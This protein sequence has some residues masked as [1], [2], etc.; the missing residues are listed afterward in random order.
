MWGVKGSPFIRPQSNGK[1]DF[2]FSAIPSLGA[3]EVEGGGARPL[4]FPCG[5]CSGLAA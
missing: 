1:E 5:L 3:T 2:P 4:K